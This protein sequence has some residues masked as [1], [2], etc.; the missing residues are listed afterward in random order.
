MLDFLVTAF[1]VLAAALA[2]FIVIVLW[3]VILYV[4][5]N[6]IRVLIKGEDDEGS[7]I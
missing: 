3:S 5:F 4:G 2:L 7:T 6:E 1:L